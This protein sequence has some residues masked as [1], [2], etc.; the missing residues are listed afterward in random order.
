MT[1]IKIINVIWKIR[2][3]LPPPKVTWSLTAAPSR[4]HASKLVSNITI[5][6]NNKGKVSSD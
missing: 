4:D 5:S 1:V 6:P 3:L 2:A